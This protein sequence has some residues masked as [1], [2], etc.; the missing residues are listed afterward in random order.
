MGRDID[1]DIYK[2][3]DDSFVRIHIP[4]ANITSFEIKGIK[5]ILQN[6]KP[7]HRFLCTGK[8]E[9]IF[10]L[11]KTNPKYRVIENMW[12]VFYYD[13]RRITRVCARIYFKS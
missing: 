2:S 9:A 10:H 6:I 11:M 1:V 13:T 5:C 3:L 12:N 7:F 4:D 8:E